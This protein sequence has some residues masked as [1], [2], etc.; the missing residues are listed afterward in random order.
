MGFG[1]C[2]RAKR[3]GIEV[4]NSLSQ[5]SRHIPQGIVVQ[6][7]SLRTFCFTWMQCAGSSGD[8]FHS[9]KEFFVDMQPPERQLGGIVNLLK[10]TSVSMAGMRFAFVHSELPFAFHRD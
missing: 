5:G 6:A 2:V 8:V 3:E 10:L 9:T 4:V 7:T 1:I